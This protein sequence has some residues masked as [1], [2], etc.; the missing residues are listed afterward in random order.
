VQ[1][2]REGGFI[3]LV[4]IVFSHQPML[5]GPGS[6]LG[7]YEI[8][9]VI[10]GG[11]MGEVY[12]AHDTKLHR[13]V[14]LKVLSGGLDDAGRRLLQEARAASALNHPHICT[15][16]EVGEADGQ[17][18]IVMEHVDGMPLSDMISKQPLPIETAIRLGIQIADALAH[19]HEH[20]I[21]HRDLKPSNVVVTRDGRAKVVDFGLALRDRDGLSDETRTRTAL[22]DLGEL[23]GTVAFMAPEVLKGHPSSVRSDVWA[24]GVMLYAMI[25]GA[26]P[27]DGK[28]PFDLTAAIQYEPPHPLPQRV[29]VSVR[30]IVMRCL[31]KE[32]S[33]RFTRAS[34][35]R[36]AL[37]A[38]RA[39][40][41]ALALPGP[42][43][44][45]KQ[46]TIALALVLVSLGAGAGI[47]TLSRVGWRPAAAPTPR[48][49]VSVLVVD[50][51]N[52]TGDPA[53][54]D[55]IEAII[56]NRIED[57]SFISSYPRHLARRAAMQMSSRKGLDESVG[58]AL[59]IQQDIKVIVSG[60]VALAQPGYVLS[61]SVIDG[62]LGK[63]LARVTA[64]APARVNAIDAAE[65]LAL[66]I[67]T[68]LGDASVPLKTGAAP[69]RGSLEA[70]RSLAVAGELAAS[71]NRDSAVQYSRRAIEEDP[72]FARAYLQ[73]FLSL[74]ELG[75]EEEAKV[76]G[77][78]LVSLAASMHDRER[79][80][81]LGSY[82]L[83]IRDYRRAGEN[84]EALLTKYPDDVVGHNNLALV[85]F[86][87]RDLPSALQSIRRAVEIFPRHITYRSNY[88]LYAMYA[89]DFDS[90]A[91]EATL[92]LNQNAA[93]SGSY[94]ALASAMLAK[95]NF[96]QARQAYSR[97]ADR[98]A[99]LA[100]LGLADLALYAG[101]APEAERIL[102]SQIKV[103]GMSTPASSR[104]YALLAE[105]YVA[106]GK[107]VHA[108]EAVRKALDVNRNIATI[109]SA[110]RVFLYARSQ[111]DAMSLAKE[112][113]RIEGREG[114]G[115]AKI[116]EAEIASQRHDVSAAVAALQLTNETPDL[117]LRR[118]ELALNYVEM[119][120]YAKAL[121]ELETCQ[122]RRGEA[123]AIF[124]DDIPSFRYLRALPYW[125]GRAQSGLGMKTPAA[126]NFRKFLDVQSSSVP[127]VLV[128]DARQRLARLEEH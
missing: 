84:Y 113:A 76:I 103:P 60:D 10:G 63:V 112:L 66:Q 43:R 111:S 80:R 18:F 14:A 55:T 72:Q 94:V 125:F 33:H 118:F 19:A 106:Q 79:Y 21:V 77:P 102:A 67:R 61:A 30:T 22:R 34:D 36:A 95:S 62:S 54:E 17:A 73:L 70:W 87:Q 99:W 109:F 5:L 100:S 50:F 47:W 45:H 24:F 39:D 110:A 46:I 9:S 105:A 104:A 75:L 26:L 28:T 71:G 38:I 108:I 29:P 126:E 42:T 92:T 15:V 56:S 1:F 58:R 7:A 86:Y 124:F 40:D 4:I 85:Y 37:E 8:L 20:G 115:Y 91:A 6:R 97:L 78:K 69:G 41:S 32:P 12:R 117:W 31:T 52:Q 25:S 74:Q 116:T 44:A 107:T 3:R 98:D 83:V 23:A 68:R 127:D 121:S 119:E 48:D 59:A 114:L 81:T 128:D 51:H 53:F 82:Y 49:L 2:M 64:N 13:V 11:G 65:S 123:A 96:A 88:A 90:A 89:S 93:A 57:S 27:F 16:H 35:I 120:E 122:K 101:N